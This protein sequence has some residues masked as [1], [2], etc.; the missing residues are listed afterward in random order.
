MAST[1]VYFYTDEGIS[2]LI[3]DLWSLSDLATLANDSGSGDG[4]TAAEVAGKPGLYLATVTEALN[5]VYLGRAKDSAGYTRGYFVFEM[6]DTVNP[7]FWS[8]GKPLRSQTILV[9][10]RQ[11]TITVRN[12]ADSS[13]IQNAHV[14]LTQTPAEQSEQTNASGQITP[15]VED[16]TYTLAVAH[17][18]YLG[19][20][21]SIAVNSSNTS[22]TV[23]LTAKV[24][25]NPS[26]PDKTDLTFTIVDSEGD[27]IANQSF[28]YWID[29]RPT[30][31]G[32]FIK[33]ESKTG[34]SNGSGVVSI[35]VLKGAGIK[36][37][38]GKSFT[39]FKVPADAGAT[40]QPQDFLWQV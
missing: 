2:G 13:P 21:Q 23:D 38:I 11:I 12:A 1:P 14:T 19:S 10:S 5:G 36:V 4:D 31:T 26:T 28:N 17:P 40:Y 30:G 18:L 3:L 24:A 7:V 33:S 37:Q 35:Q 32:R 39:T 6:T 29:Q 16:G 8:E 25:A 22:F 34:Q 20:S 27:G 9:G 15:S